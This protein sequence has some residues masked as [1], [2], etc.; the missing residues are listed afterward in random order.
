MIA[1]LLSYLAYHRALPLAD[2]DIDLAKKLLAYR[3]VFGFKP[4]LA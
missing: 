3:N 2:L 4:G 1:S